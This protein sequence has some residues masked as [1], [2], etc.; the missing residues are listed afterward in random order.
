MNGQG[1]RR[2]LTRLAYRFSWDSR[3][4]NT[5]AAD[6]LR[7]LVDAGSSGPGPRGYAVLDAGS[8]ELGVREFLPGS[9]IIGF[10]RNHVSPLLPFVVGD[11]TAFPFPDRAV[12]LVSCI[13]VI[14]HLPVDLRPVAIAELL[15]ITGVGLVIAFPQGDNAYQCDKR[16]MTELQSRGKVPPSWICEHQA[17]PYPDAEIV[18]SEVEAAGEKLGYDVG[19]STRYAEP[20]WVSTLIRAAGARS[21]ALFMAAN[22]VFGLLLPVMRPPRPDRA[23]RA[24]LVV[25]VSS[26]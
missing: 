16:Y 1:V 22:L 18:R 7:Q 3:C 2:T 10:D 8:A 12:P 23:Y 6:A 11:I 26:R 4:R 15:R 13:D 24:V 9:K 20:T 5:V 25:T 14:E 19:V 17:Y 21:S